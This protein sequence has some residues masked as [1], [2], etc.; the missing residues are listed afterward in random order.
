MMRTLQQCQTVA[1][2]HFAPDVLSEHE[3]AQLRPKCPLM[4][5]GSGAVTISPSTICQRWQ[6]EIHE[7][8]ADHQSP[9]PHKSV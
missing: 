4:P 8:R 2:R 5:V 1:H 3:T 6:P 9:A 7:W